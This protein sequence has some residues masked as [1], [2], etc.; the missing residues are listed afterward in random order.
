MRNGS[1]EPSSA[2]AERIAAAIRHHAREADLP[3]GAHLAEQE[4]ADRFLVSRS[5]VRE[6][7]ALLEA[8]GLVERRRHRGSFLLH[9]GRDLAAEARP[10]RVD[11]DADYARIAE[12]R[13]DGRLPERITEA[14]L[15][16]RYGLSRSRILT[17][18]GR[19]QQ[20]GWADRLP[21]HGWQFLPTL[22]TTAAYEDGY[23][24]RAAIEPAALLSPGFV[25]DPA[26]LAR[27]RAEQ[28]ALLG[29]GL[30]QLPRSALFHVHAGYHES[31]VALS[32]NAFFVEGLRR[33][34]RLRRLIEYRNVLEPARLVQQAEEH[35]AILDR[36]EAGDVQGAATLME[37]HLRTMRRMRQPDGR[38]VVIDPR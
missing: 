11:D 12:D 2:L 35:L 30:S 21:G 29:G 22:A 10:M 13:L 24:F 28:Q 37:R 6:A 34:N 7:L 3:A 26:V 5:P 31:L 17:L 1:L 33:V 38:T 18:L 4:L 27:L 15:G 32:G 14:A 16:R 20:E 8:Q 36:I 25:P 9:P 19:M 23:R